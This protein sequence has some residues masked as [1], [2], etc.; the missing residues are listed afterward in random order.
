MAPKVKLVYFKTEGRAEVIRI[1]LSQAGVDFEDKRLSKE[2]W[3]AMK[4]SEWST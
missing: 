1:I 2:E 3:E 4:P